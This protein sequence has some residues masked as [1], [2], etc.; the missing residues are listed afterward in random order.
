MFLKTGMDLVAGHA[1]PPF[2]PVDMEIVEVPISIAE[3][4]QG[5]GPF[6]LYQVLVMALKTEG[7]EFRVIGVIELL[8]KKGFQYLNIG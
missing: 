2:F 5:R 8:R 6:I 7:I 3:V 1:R 4:G